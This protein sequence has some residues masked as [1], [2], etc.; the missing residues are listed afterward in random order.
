MATICQKI[1]AM[2]NFLVNND[3]P[4][5]TTSQLIAIFEIKKMKNHERY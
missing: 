5:V 4:F 2:M 3:L 1:M